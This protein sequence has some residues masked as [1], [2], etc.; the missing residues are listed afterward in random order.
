M[1]SILNIIPF[2]RQVWTIAVVLLI[3]I[4]PVRAY[5]DEF[6]YTNILIGDRASSMG[7]AYF[8]VSDDPSGLYYNPAGIVYASGKNLSVSANAFYD[9]RKNYHYVIGGHGWLRNSSALLPNFFGIVQPI[10][11]LKFGISY[12]VPDSILE[13][14]DQTFYSLPAAL[15][16]S[17][18]VD[19]YVIDF[20]NED[21]TYN[22]GPSMAFELGKDL[23][24]G[25]TLYIHKRGAQM[26]QNELVNLSDGRY[27]WTN[28]YFETSEWGVKPLLGIIWSPIDKVSIGLIASRI[29]VIESQT[30]GMTTFKDIN[31]ERNTLSRVVTIKTDKRQYPYQLGGGLAYFPSKSVLFAMDVTYF[32]AVADESDPSKNKASVVNGSF[33][34]EYFVTKNYAIRA[35][36]YTNMSNTYDVKQGYLG[37]SEH[38]NMYGGT[39][40]VSNYSKSTSI[41]MGGGM[42]YGT[43]LAQI[44]RGAADIQD[45]DSL[46]W[47]LFLSSAYSY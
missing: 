39:F 11:N 10:G 15:G 29:I 24:A 9:V 2:S 13:N 45:V 33:G 32:T 8:A 41:T 23:G 17:T 4:C 20:K 7:G 36:G 14:Q 27:E 18:T 34:F 25:V 37:Q 35:G 28:T 12:A 6:H 5:A 47:T 38:I 42:S 21:T 3:A 16:N 1:T 30:K 43:G 22:A 31:Y 19:R 44:R 46:S 26:I 40:S